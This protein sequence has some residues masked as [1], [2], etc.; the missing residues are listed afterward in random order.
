VARDLQGSR[1][2]I[3]HF[4]ISLNLAGETRMAKVGIFHVF[5]SGAGGQAH[6]SSR[7]AAALMTKWLELFSKPPSA[8]KIDVL[9]AK[10]PDERARP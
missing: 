7:V 2:V 6:L 10:L 3:G 5:A 9:G 8:E 4:E 1:G